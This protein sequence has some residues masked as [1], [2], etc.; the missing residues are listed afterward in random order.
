MVTELTK[1]KDQSNKWCQPFADTNRRFAILYED[2]ARSAEVFDDE[3]SARNTFEKRSDNWN[4]TLMGALPAVKVDPRKF[5]RISVVGLSV[6]P[7]EW[8]KVSEA[9]RQGITPFLD[10]SWIAE[11]TDMTW[12]TIEEREEGWYWS[13]QCEGEIYQV[14]LGGADFNNL[15]KTLSEAKRQVQDHHEDLIRRHLA[16]H[17]ELVADVRKMSYAIERDRSNLAAGI[18]KMKAVIESRSWL[19]HDRGSYEYDDDK[20][21]LEFRDAL[22][23]LRAELDA[24]SQIASDWT[25]CPLDPEGAR[26]ARLPQDA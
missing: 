4:C 25:H 14:K 5:E 3:H 2:Q 1:E 15:P 24:L 17:E 21:Q 18:Q 20:Y 8:L 6:L 10:G 26:E 12:Y 19:E 23:E 11:C 16:D 9:N 22:R 13:L 7:L